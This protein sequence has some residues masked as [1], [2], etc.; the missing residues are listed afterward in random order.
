MQQTN[1][2]IRP[3]THERGSVLILCVVVLV[4]IAMLGLAMLQDAKMDAFSVDRYERNYIDEVINA[5]IGEISLRLDKD[6]EEPMQWSGPLY[7]YPWT[8]TGVT[9]S[10]TLDSGAT[11]TVPY[12]GFSDTVIPTSDYWLASTTPIIQNGATI[13]SNQNT[14]PHLT[15]I[16]GVWLDIPQFN[17]STVLVPRETPVRNNSYNSTADAQME[18]RDTN[19]PFDFLMDAATPSGSSIDPSDPSA[20]YEARGVDTDQDNIKDARWTWAPESVRN[21]GGRKY[22][23]AIRIA[24]LSSL[25]N[26]NTALPNTDYN[27]GLL[28]SDSAR[29]YTPASA[30]FGRL[31]HATLNAGPD[32]TEHTINATTI[33]EDIDGLFNRRYDGLTLTPTDWPVDATETT[34]NPNNNQQTTP[35]VA[36]LSE[37]DYIWRAQASQ[38]GNTANNYIVNDELELRLKGGLNQYDSISSIEDETLAPPASTY[39]IGLANV[40][41]N[42]PN[43]PFGTTAGHTPPETGINTIIG[44][45]GDLQTWFYGKD[46]ATPFDPRTNTINLSS[47]KLPAIRHMLTTASGSA[48]Y[49]PNYRPS[50]AGPT[51]FGS[52]NRRFKIDLQSQITDNAATP[53]NEAQEHV[54]S[55]A[56]RIYMCFAYPEASSDQWYLYDSA[57]LANTIDGLALNVDQGQA[58][59]AAQY[60][61]AIADY[62]DQDLQPSVVEVNSKQYFGSEKLPYIREVYT[63]VLYQD[64]NLGR[65]LDPDGIPNNGDE[66]RI[67]PTLSGGA[68]NPNYS[69]SLTLAGDAPYSAAD[70]YD[71]WIPVS[72]TQAI[73]IELGNPFSHPIYGIESGTDDEDGLHSEDGSG[74]VTP[75]YR[76]VLRQ[77]GTLVGTW[78][79]DINDFRAGS[80]LLPTTGS[81]SNRLLFEAR[82]DTAG[83]YDDTVVLVFDPQTPTADSNGAGSTLSGAAT[84]D[85]TTTEMGLDRSNCSWIDNNNLAFNTDSTQITIQL[86]VKSNNSTGTW[87][88]YDSFNT[89]IAFE[90]EIYRHN[91][92]DWR[93]SAIERHKQESAFRDSHGIRYIWDDGTAANNQRTTSRDIDTETEYKNV[94]DGNFAQLTVTGIANADT[95]GTFTTATNPTAGVRSIP[96]DML[97]FHPDRPMRSITELGLVTITG[98]VVNGGGIIT[99]QSNYLATAGLKDNRRTLALDATVSSLNAA[100]IHPD[101]GSMMLP[102]AALL[103]DHFT[104]VSPSDDNIDNDQNGTVDDSGNGRELFIPGTINVNTMPLNLLTLSSPLPES[105]ITDIE[106]LSRSIV[107][108]R[109]GP[110]YEQFNP[111]FTDFDTSS[112]YEYSDI[113]DTVATNFGVASTSWRQTTS[114]TDQPGIASIGELLYL[115][116]APGVSSRNMNREGVNTSTLTATSKLNLFPIPEATTAAGINASSTGAA[117]KNEEF[118]A[119]LQYLT[120]LYSV[121][122][123][124]FVVYGYVRG[125]PDGNFAAGPIEEARFIAVLDRSGKVT[126]THGPYI[127]GYNRVN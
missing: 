18:E 32:M 74:V 88:T 95:K 36:Q 45:D 114:N 72:E 89:G 52:V 102:H 56:K 20:V 115:N 51:P 39:Q 77:G 21:I 111:T 57:D 14:W 94:D 107:C 60:A 9:E 67:F 68:P 73:A 43:L 50:T 126:T 25:I 61:A 47:Y 120:Q 35:S 29:G 79:F 123:D 86:Q 53:V 12:V 1:T 16:S 6:I 99:P 31:L 100:T 83:A 80:P 82:D 65:M 125:Y 69:T 64:T 81:K 33:G 46:N 76:I 40:L 110:L 71:S 93:S 91:A 38:Y 87:I 104:T 5:T 78:D 34:F 13:D 44:V 101:S 10:I 42:K 8:D 70:R 108:Y 103:F 41:R 97:L 28:I 62:T 63:Q 90:D 85:P 96:D 75:I 112:P 23:V 118:L 122:S 121:R 19:V 49:A 30:D 48:I 22:V 55:M 15:N 106:D 113:R 37:R 66:S 92:T 54:D 3:L 27:T 58:A 116:P 117:D 105:S 109:D 17:Q 84:S 4:I 2:N 124:R 98:S 11:V 119:R 127:Y 7:D 24:D 59:L 26:I